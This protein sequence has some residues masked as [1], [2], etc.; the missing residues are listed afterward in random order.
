MRKNYLKYIVFI[1]LTPITLLSACG[2]I[3]SVISAASPT[4]TST[5]S[6]V[7]TTI[8]EEKVQEIR[9]AIKEKV[10]EI[11]QKIEKKAYVGTITQITDSTL[12][13]ENFRGKQRV[14]FIEDTTIIGTNKKE[15]K[16]SDLA[17]DDKVIC[18]GSISEN[19]IL[20]AKRVIVVTVPKTAPAKRLV[21]YGRISEIDSKNSTVTVNSTKNLDFSLEIKVDQNTRLNSY[22]EPKTSIK[23]KDLKQDQKIIVI[24]PETTEGK[25]PLA[26]AVFILP[27]D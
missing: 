21:I 4:P 8:E 18:M 24:Y 6:A 11:K 20:E 9:D 12:T 16:F 1:I 19:E 5:P 22:S 27:E 3:F 7:P 13:L 25:I 14:R 15:I 17:V 10:D 23:Y 26:R 2:G